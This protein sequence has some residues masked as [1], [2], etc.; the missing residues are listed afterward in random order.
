MT[1]L[2][3][4][5]AKSSIRTTNVLPPRKL[6]QLGRLHSRVVQHRSDT[7]ACVVL[8]TEK[9]HPCSQYCELRFLTL[10]ASIYLESKVLAKVLPLQYTAPLLLS[11]LARW[12]SL[13]RKRQAFPSHLLS[14]K[15]VKG[16]ASSRVVGFYMFFQV[17][18]L[19]KANWTR[20]VPRVW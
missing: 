20:G 10:K 18:C 11:A 6:L 4:G 3:I 9:M 7:P 19:S 8:V 5:K 13:Y 2:K 14:S 12:L 1:W 16:N 15:V 17:W